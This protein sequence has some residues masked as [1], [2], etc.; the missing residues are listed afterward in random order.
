[1]LPG[2]G[3]KGVAEVLNV[4]KQGKENTKEHARCLNTLEHLGIL[5]Y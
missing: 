3:C 1:M 2:K 4:Y 5:S